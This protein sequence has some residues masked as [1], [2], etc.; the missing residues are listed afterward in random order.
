MRMCR[1]EPLQQLRVARQVSAIPT[2]DQ[3]LPQV[4]PNNQP[5][6][7]NTEHSRLLYFAPCNACWI[8]AVLHVSRFETVEPACESP[9][10]VSSRVPQHTPSCQTRRTELSQP[11]SFDVAR[12]RRCKAAFS[13]RELRRSQNGTSEP[14]QATKRPVSAMVRP[15]T[16]PSSCCTA[17]C[18]AVRTGHRSR[19]RP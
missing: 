7:C 6:C 4:L 19:P 14:S 12:I 11:V 10:W 1:Q 13:P 2:D 15:S 16:M 3:S 18:N 5:C 17:R 8:S 9:C